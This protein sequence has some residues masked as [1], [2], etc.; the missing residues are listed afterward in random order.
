LPEN[1]PRITKARWAKKFELRK[2]VF[3]E[4]LMNIQRKVV[5]EKMAK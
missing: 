3:M 2:K 4:N 5:E 1:S